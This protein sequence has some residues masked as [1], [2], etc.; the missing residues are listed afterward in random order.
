M[1]GYAKV[2]RLMMHHT[3]KSCVRGFKALS[4]QNL[5]YLQAELV[6]LEAEYRKL[7]IADRK[8]GHPCR[9][10]YEKSYRLLSQSQLDGNDDQFQKFLQIRAKLKEYCT[11]HVNSRWY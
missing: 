9:E 4:L 2:A 1:D 6:Q 3:E 8:S 10:L 7:A 5:L 11:L